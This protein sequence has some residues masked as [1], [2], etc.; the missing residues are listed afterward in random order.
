M[1]ND[2][3]LFGLF[4]YMIGVLDQNREIVVIVKRLNIIENSNG[5]I[6]HFCSL[7]FKGAHHTKL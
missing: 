1:Y 6:T 5:D 7:P 3:R 4:L 2:D